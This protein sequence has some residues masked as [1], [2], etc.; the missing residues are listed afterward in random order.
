[1]NKPTYEELLAKVTELESKAARKSTDR[2]TKNGLTLRV[3]P[4]GAISVYGLGKWPASLYA[5]QMVKLLSAGV[6]IGE[7]IRDN[8]DRLSVKVADKDEPETGAETD[9]TADAPPAESEIPELA[10]A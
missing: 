3:S 7:F 8:A 2:K 10:V 1:M 9:N 5:S 6:E 4:K